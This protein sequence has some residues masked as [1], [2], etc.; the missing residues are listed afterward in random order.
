MQTPRVTVRRNPAQSPARAILSCVALVVLSAS[1]ANADQKPPSPEMTY[2]SLQTLPDW[3]GWWNYNQPLITE[4]T[5]SPPP[6]RPEDIANIRTSN[7]LD[8]NPDPKRWCRPYQFVGYSGGFVDGVEFLFTPGRVTLLNESGLV[9]RI[10]TDGRPLPPNVEPSNP[11][12][13]VGHWEGETLVV[14]TFGI[15]PK[16]LFPALA[17]GAPPIGQNARITERITLRNANTL[18]FDVTV[19]APD[20]LTAPD[21]RKR[22][23]L[24]ASKERLARDVSFCVDFD[25]SIDP[26]TGKQ[27]FDMTPPKDLPPPPPK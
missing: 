7:R 21:H 11:G 20:V 4:I 24:R 14:D 13:S 19:V 17:A 8:Q 23:Y 18:E 22:L 27:R 6:M 3:S 1:S 9:R 15:N 10:Y 12:T 25:R 26:L 5:R 2:A 16:S